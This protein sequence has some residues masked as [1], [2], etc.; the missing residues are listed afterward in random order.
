MKATIKTFI[1]EKTGALSYV[2]L[3]E[4]QVLWSGYGQIVR[5]AL[6]GATNLANPV[7]KTVVVKHVDLPDE[8]LHPRGWNTTI[9]HQRKVHSY[10][11]EMNWYQNWASRCNEHCRVPKNFGTL[12]DGQ[13]FIVILEDLD[14]SG[15]ALRINDASLSDMYPCL[16]WLANFHALF[17]MESP[18]GLWD[19]GTYWHLA[20][21]P[22]ELAALD[23]KE[24]KQNAP[25]IDKTLGN[26]RWQ[27][28]VHGDAKLA[29][30]CFS[31]D[32][33]KV[34]A[35]DFQYVGKGCGM[36]DA[37]YFIGSCLSEDEC[38]QHESTLLD[39][40]FKELVAA[41]K[42]SEAKQEHPIDYVD[43]EREWRDM[44]PIAWT[45]FYRFLKGWSP[46]H[47]KIHRYS[48]RLAQET[49]NRLSK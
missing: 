18:V 9:S 23:D 35:V 49:L 20:T 12:K 40:Y 3:E 4:I 36:K 26:A 42:R 32:R 1:L 15:Y 10:H 29:N 25:V 17:L 37:A 14:A 28:L 48:E 27:T 16:S 39:Y 41:L 45:D 7:P 21:R 6:Q 38:E 8:N 11:V 31:L 22:D 43:L 47:W 13:E 19:T 46:D 2:E 30:F 24:L 5:L 33:Q 34:A 44:Y